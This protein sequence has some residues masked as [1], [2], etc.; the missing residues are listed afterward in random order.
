MLSG[1]G[2]GDSYAKDFRC[3]FAQSLRNINISI[4]H[5]RSETRNGLNTY[6]L[7]KM[8]ETISAMLYNY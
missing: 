2:T 3:Y 4:L 7:V 8:F 1:M 6:I 5:F